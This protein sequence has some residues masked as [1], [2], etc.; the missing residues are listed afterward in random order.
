MA[1]ALRATRVISDE[2]AQ[3]V[4]EIEKIFAELTSWRNIFAAQWEEAA[5]LLVPDFRNTFF[6]GSYNWPGMKK[7][8]QQVD[9]TGG[10]ALKQF[11]AIA[12]SLVT[13]K[14]RKW[15]G[16][17][18]DRY[19]MKDRE[20]RE[21]FDQV[22]DI[23]FDYRYRPV[24]N[25][26]AQNYSNWKSLGAFG[27]AIMYVDAYDR[28]WLGGAR[29][30]RYKSVPLGECFWA[31]N[32][33][34]IVTTM[35]R[36]FRLTAAQ[37]AEKWG[38]DAIPAAM[39]PS[40][41][42]NLQSPWQFL[43]C[44]RPRA[45]E[46]FDPKRLD[47][48]GKAFQSCYVSVEGKCLMEPEGGYI[49][50]PYAVSRYDQMPN[51]QYGRGPAQLVL[52]ALK[53]LNAQKAVFLKTGHRASD[54]VLLTSDDGLIDF[55]QTPG[56]MNKGG[57][58]AD[59]RPM[60]HAL[61]VGDIQ[62]TEK[63]ML[64][65]RGL[66]EQHFLT[67]LFKVLTENPNMTATQ[68]VELLNERGMLVAPE[69]GRQHAEYVGGLADREIS[70][71][72][73]MR[74]LPPMPMR[75]REAAGYYEVTDTS[76][77][78]DAA[79]AQKAAGFMRWA[80]FGKQIAVDTGDPSVLDRLDFDTAMPEIGRLQGVPERWISDDRAMMAKRKSR[81]QAQAAKQQ[82]DAM[83]AQAA[84]IKA[85]AVAAKAGAGQPQGGGGPAPAEPQL[86]Q[87]I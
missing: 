22:T 60:V 57:V 75:L 13:P 31:E 53:T 24:A 79:Q 68:V 86:P 33:Q 58:N 45:E 12:D 65:E 28:R 5:I 26:H 11:C 42:Q 30:I 85:N 83:P 20:T 73:A 8:Q 72:S 4:H 48:K 23:L 77:L 2:E 25:F 19:V 50:F 49:T 40:L 70:L 66:I 54:P 81:A 67:S 38:V 84:M 52:P 27:N 47:E 74:L 29:G 39:W 36:W 44:V 32:H 63:M 41:E 35:V 76:P 69:L 16:L 10:L 56:A 37:A 7:T 71:L 78:A 1:T 34:G 59:G 64:E 21:W 15:H 55:D 6:Y 14:N 82:V 18:S 3:T 46:T 62:I 80:D 43:H 9:A 51:E 17:R 61:P 87:Q